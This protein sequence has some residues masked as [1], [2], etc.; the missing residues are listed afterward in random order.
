M[1]TILPFTVYPKDKRD[2]GKKFMV[3]L[4]GGVAAKWWILPVGEEKG[5]M[6]RNYIRPC[7]ICAQYGENN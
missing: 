2:N 7:K 3:L 5:T 1:D 4:R 6:N